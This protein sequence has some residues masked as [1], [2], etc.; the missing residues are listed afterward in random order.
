MLEVLPSLLTLLRALVHRLQNLLLC[1]DF[2]LGLLGS[3]CLHLRTLRFG[4]ILERVLCPAMFFFGRTDDAFND[5][6]ATF[7]RLRYVTDLRGEVG[8][9]LANSDKDIGKEKAEGG[10]G[11]KKDKEGLDRVGKV[12]SVL[13]YLGR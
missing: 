13:L 6:R 5:L 2:D 12:L 4:V 11:E 1:I 3:H 8:Q 7:D 10:G 9:S